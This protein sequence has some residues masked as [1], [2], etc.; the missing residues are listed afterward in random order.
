M[1]GKI[2]HKPQL[3]MFKVQLKSLVS[4]DHSLIILSHKIDWASIDKEFEQY[5]SK[6]GRPS[7]PTRTMVGLLMLKSIF[8]ESDET[9]IP[10]WVENPYWQYF[11]GEQFFRHDQPCDPSDLVHFRK[12]IQKTGHEYLLKVSA[13]LHGKASQQSIV[14]IDTTVQEKDIT[15]P[16]DAKL[17]V[18]ILKE[19][20]RLADKCNLKLHQNYTR[21]TSEAKLKVRFWN[22]PRRKKE[23]RQAVKDLRKYARKVIGQLRNHLS[24]EQLEASKSRFERYA[25]VLAQKKDDK[26]KIYSLHEPDV[27][28]MSKGKSHKPYEY[29]CKV[30]LGVTAQTGVIVAVTSFEENKNDFHTL[31]QTLEQIKYTTGKLPKEVICDR[32][33]RGKKKIGDTLITIPKPLPANSTRYQKEKVRIKFRRRAAIEPIIGHL[34]QD[35]RM[36]RNFLKGNLGDFVNCV[37]AGA[38]FNLKKMLRK[39]AS[40]SGSLTNWFYSIIYALLFKNDKLLK[41]AF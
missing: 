10:R 26:H 12:R 33:Y 14:T 21:K 25:K 16:T 9:L 18:A 5:Y 15:Y 4:Q 30:S 34:K 27:Y 38:G 8:N 29:G 24:A 19:C 7:V 6:E 22:H 40:S 31:E 20:W 17:A 41:A 13:G 28:C 35:H 32:G 11:C 36:A 39:I 2:K 37:L 1:Q 3:D 23:A